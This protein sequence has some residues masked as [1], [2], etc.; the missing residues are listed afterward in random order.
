M[1]LVFSFLACFRWYED[2]EIK[3]QSIR[4]IARPMLST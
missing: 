2:N 1:V 4:H 3:D